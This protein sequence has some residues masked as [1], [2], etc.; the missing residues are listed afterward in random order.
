MASAAE[1]MVKVI[2]DLSE[3]KEQLQEASLLGGVVR[4]AAHDLLFQYSEWLD[5]QG[6]VRSEKQSGDSRSHDQLVE[7]FLN[8]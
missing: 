6:I 4:R 3:F 8:R 5:S 7:D 1:M 2:P